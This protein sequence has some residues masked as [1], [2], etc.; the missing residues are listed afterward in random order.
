MEQNERTCEH[1]LFGTKAGCKFECRCEFQS[2][3]NSKSFLQS[4]SLV[5]VDTWLKPEVEG[6]TAVTFIQLVTE[7]LDYS[8]SVN[9]GIALRS[10]A[11]I[12]PING[13]NRSAK[14]WHTRRNWRQRNRSNTAVNWP[15]A[16]ARP[17]E[18]IKKNEEVAVVDVLAEV[19]V[20]VVVLVEWR[21]KKRKAKLTQLYQCGEDLRSWNSACVCV[22]A[23]RENDCV[24]GKVS[25]VGGWVVKKGKERER[26]KSYSED[27]I[28]REQQQWKM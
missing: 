24:A 22:C 19:V 14:D 27:K 11:V 15:I 21:N 13:W 18:K 1:K 23:K 20:V 25:W 2:H 3:F 6:N 17:T 4:K 9:E 16:H 26:E 8:E 10:N 28:R 12:H 7:T 5:V